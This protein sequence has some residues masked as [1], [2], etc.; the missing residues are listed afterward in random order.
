MF[1]Y[2]LGEKSVYVIKVVEGLSPVL[3]SRVSVDVNVVGISVCGGM[4]SNVM[5]VYDEAGSLKL[6]RAD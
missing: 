4:G 1:I 3:Q 5:A 6:F 2:A